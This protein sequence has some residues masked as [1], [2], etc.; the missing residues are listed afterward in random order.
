MSETVTEDSRVQLIVNVSHSKPFDESAF[1]RAVQ[2]ILALPPRET[3][4]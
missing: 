2:A 3:K 4:P 1:R